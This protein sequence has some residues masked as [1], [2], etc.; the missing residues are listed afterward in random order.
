[1]G[2]ILA[3][4]P[5]RRAKSKWLGLEIGAVVVI[6][7]VFVTPFAGGW[8]FPYHLACSESARGPPA[9]LWTPVVLLNSPFRGS[10]N[11][12]GLLIENGAPA[13][14]AGGTITAVNGSSEGLFALAPWQ[15]YS[16]SNQWVLGDGLGSPCIAPELATLLPGAIA[17]PNGSWVTPVQLAAPG[18]VY[19]SNVPTQLALDG[20]ESVAFDLNFNDSVHSTGG[21]G[22]CGAEGVGLA[23]SLEAINV[24]V[25]L[26]GY[27][28]PA[29]VPDV[30]SLSYFL[31]PDGN[32]LIEVTPS[33]GLAFDFY[34]CA[35]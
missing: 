14:G 13:P 3:P 15:L 27:H 6:A 20:Y 24:T 1:M 17:S 5:R 23:Q 7:L 2:D 10:A 12:T 8:G 19:S 34:P 25:P 22:T 4:V 11:A 9:I 26:G 32:W 30:V 21:H 29:Q 35:P 31:G 18:N 33:A 16:T 28:L